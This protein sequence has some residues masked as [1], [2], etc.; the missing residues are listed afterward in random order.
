M[1]SSFAIS[2]MAGSEHENDH[3]PE[4]AGLPVH[5]RDFPWLWRELARTENC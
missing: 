1:V 3:G 2:L 5:P 4:T